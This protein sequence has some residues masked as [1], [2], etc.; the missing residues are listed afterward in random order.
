MSFL[1][2]S[3]A[4]SKSAAE[5]SSG[6]AAACLIVCTV[7]GIAA[8][9]AIAS[10][11]P[12]IGLQGSALVDAAIFGVLGLYILR[13]RSRVA[14]VL[15]LLLY[16][17]EMIGTAVLHGNFKFTVVMF[18]FLAYLFHGVR[19]TFA[20]ASHMKRDSEGGVAESSAKS[21]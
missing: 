18:F 12:V 4:N 3:I 10:S 21:G 11:H 7:T 19:G 14:A 17:A 15:A 13:R 9:A 5:A 6:A 2:P 20:Y 16:V 1:W 8:I